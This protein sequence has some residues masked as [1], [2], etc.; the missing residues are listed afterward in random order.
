[1][2]IYLRGLLFISTLS[3]ADIQEYAKK[4]EKFIDISK[5]MSVAV[6][7]RRFLNLMLP[8]IIKVHDELMQ[9]YEK[10]KSDIDAG[11]TNTKEIQALKK[12]YRVDSDED[13]LYA[14]KPHPKSIVLAQAAIESAWATSRFFIQ[15]NNVFGVWSTN[16][17]QNRIA[18]GQ[19]RGDRTIWVRKYD[20]LEQSVRE[21]YRMIGRGDSYF[22]LRMYRYDSDDVCLIIQGLDKYSEMG[23]KY[24]NVISNVIRHNNFTKYDK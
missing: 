15:A 18:A 14:L 17:S 20:N 16:P 10:I 22:D 7:K 3:M 8:P 21:Y 19:K 12:V 6:K 1:M 24:V 13:L 4:V 5:S 23:Y 2:K 11:K 9:Q